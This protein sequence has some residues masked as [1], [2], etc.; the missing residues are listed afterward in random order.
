MSVT[1]QKRPKGHRIFGHP[2]QAKLYCIEEKRT[3]TV[4]HGGGCLVIA[5]II[6]V[7]AAI[8]YCT[9][10]YAQSYLQ[11][12]ASTALFIFKVGYFFSHIMKCV[13]FL[14][15]AILYALMAF[16][17]PTTEIG[18]KVRGVSG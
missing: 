10:V 9:L 6:Q 3:V 16:V 12:N 11:T 2:I 14:Y 17:D 1:E 8:C 15:L 13:N 7:R 18:G 5:V 4:K